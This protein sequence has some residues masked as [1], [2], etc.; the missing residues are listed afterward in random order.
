M[1]VETMAEQLGLP[2]AFIVKIANGASHQ[3]K[4]YSIAKRGGGH[5]II[6]HPSRRL[7]ALQRWIDDN[8]L[9]SLPVHPAAFAYRKGRSTAHNAQH[10][11][12]SRY[13]LRID[14]QNFFPSIREEDFH[15]YLNFN[16]KRFEGWSADDFVLISKLLFRYGTLSIG[17]PT[18]PS[19]SNAICFPLDVALQS[20]A[21]ANDVRYTRY[22]DDLFFSSQQKGVLA[23]L[24]PLISHEVEKLPFPSHLR[25]NQSKTR[26]SSKKGARRVTGITLGSDGEIHVPRPYKR[27]IR[28]LIYKWD[29]LGDDEKLRVQGLIAYVTGVEPD[30]ANKLALKYGAGAMERVYSFNLV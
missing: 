7:K 10:H 3:Y 30:F 23:N 15:S 9:S 27:Q 2:P 1:I 25:V 16:P 29:Q 19:L 6:H 5:R 28:T 14:L 26:H 13:L 22:A 4:E 8:I 21:D 24:E 11:A 18:S 12:T 20:V 17:A